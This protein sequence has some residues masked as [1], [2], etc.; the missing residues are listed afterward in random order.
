MIYE[1][2]LVGAESI[3]ILCTTEINTHESVGVSLG[4]HLRLKHPDHCQVVVSPE[5]TNLW[6][7][8]SSSQGRMTMTS[9]FTDLIGLPVQEQL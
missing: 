9:A 6:M 7:S 2:P 4:K 3:C 8:V 1:A 5:C